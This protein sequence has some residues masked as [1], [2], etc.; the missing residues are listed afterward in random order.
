M[1]WTLKVGEAIVALVATIIVCR[2]TEGARQ[3]ESKRKDNE[4]DTEDM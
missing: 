4:D 1:S 2:F 3:R